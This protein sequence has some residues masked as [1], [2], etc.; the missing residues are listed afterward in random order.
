MTKQDLITGLYLSSIVSLVT[1]LA[2]IIQTIR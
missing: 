1:M 2:F